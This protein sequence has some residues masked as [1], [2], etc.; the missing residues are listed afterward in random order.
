[1]GRGHDQARPGHNLLQDRCL[2]RGEAKM[3]S[4]GSAM[5]S[6]NR[7]RWWPWDGWGESLHW[8]NCS[9]TTALDVRISEFCHLP[10]NLS[11]SWRE[12]DRLASAN[13]DEK[14]ETAFLKGFLFFG[15]GKIYSGQEKRTFG[16]AMHHC[17]YWRNL[18]CMLAITA[19]SFKIPTIGYWCSLSCKYAWEYKCEEEAQ[20]NHKT[21]L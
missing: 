14:G 19:H 12:N 20:T 15:L 18:F 9:T 3:A 2:S 8:M 1:M 21:H 13:F 11:Q 4:K 7:S 6:G 16:T 17:S 5:R 10:A